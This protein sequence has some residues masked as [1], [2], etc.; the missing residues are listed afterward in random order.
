MA[1]NVINVVPLNTA[2]QRAAVTTATSGATLVAAQTGKR[3]RVLAMVAITTLANSINLDSGT[4][5]ITGIFPL[6]ANGG[7]VLPFCEHGWC[8]T[9]AG[10]ALNV[11]ISVATSTGIQLIYMVI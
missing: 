10:E 1:M 7:L 11:T 2:V 8:E 4:T 5:D 9:A 6:A 3:I